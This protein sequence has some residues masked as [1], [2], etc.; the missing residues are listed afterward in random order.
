MCTVNHNLFAR[1]GYL[2]DVAC[3]SIAAKVL[4][5]R[6]LNHHAEVALTGEQITGLIDLNAGYQK[7]LVALRIEFAQVSEQLEHKGGRL[8]HDALTSRK[9]LLDRHVELFRAEE[10]LFFDYG[11]RGHGLL[12]DEQIS[13]VDRLY[14]AEKDA[15]LDDLAASLNSAVGPAYQ[16]TTATQQ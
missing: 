1:P 16:F 13:A 10:E 11:A 2:I 9:T 4:F 6:M 12:T 15:A 7:E 8:D 3:E 14:H 5:T